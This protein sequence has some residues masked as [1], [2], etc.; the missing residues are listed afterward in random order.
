[1]ARIVHLAL[2]LAASG[3]LFFQDACLPDVAADENKCY[4][5]V[6]AINLKDVKDFGPVT[7]ESEFLN[8]KIILFLI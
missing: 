5:K 3:E 6:S 1:M 7:P 8:K 2:I 4:S